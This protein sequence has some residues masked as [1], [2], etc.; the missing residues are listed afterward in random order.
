MILYDVTNYNLNLKD[1]KI[2]DNI[3]AENNKF[4]KNFLCKITTKIKWEYLITLT[5]CF[6]FFYF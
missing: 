6:G 5:I 3:I 1:N 4:C 2:W